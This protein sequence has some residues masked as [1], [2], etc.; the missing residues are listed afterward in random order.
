MQNNAKWKELPY[1]LG[2]NNV[3]IQDWN[4]LLHCE[5]QINF[6]ILIFDFWSSY[7]QYFIS[8]WCSQ[9]CVNYFKM[10]ANAL[11]TQYKCGGQQ[12]MNVAVIK[13]R[14][15]F[16]YQF[17][18]AASMSAT[19]KTIWHALN[20]HFQ[21]QRWNSVDMKFWSASPSICSYF[22]LP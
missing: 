4:L 14:A 19:E 12:M 2:N 6:V 8:S 7:L 10:F 18:V 16:R 13:L 21:T 20:F 11:W 5:A 1:P 17:E 22:C 3:I 9:P 15:L